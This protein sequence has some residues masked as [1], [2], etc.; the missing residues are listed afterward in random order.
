M[1]SRV[2]HSSLLLF[3]VQLLHKLSI[4]AADGPM[5]LMKV[6]FVSLYPFSLYVVYRLHNSFF[7]VV[8]LQTIFNAMITIFSSKFSS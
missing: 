6:S 1:G 4:H 2:Q 5:K 7:G 8:F 3:P